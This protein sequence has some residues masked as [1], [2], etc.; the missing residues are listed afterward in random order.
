MEEKTYPLLLNTA[1]TNVI[2]KALGELPAKETWELIV[3][4]RNEWHAH[5]QSTPAKVKS[6][7]K[8]N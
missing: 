3:K 2:L 7:T 5:N 8:K 4:I 6:V 1:E